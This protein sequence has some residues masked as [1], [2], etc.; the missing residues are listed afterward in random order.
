MRAALDHYGVPYTYFADQKLRDGNLRAKYDV[1]IYPARRR[2]FAVASDRHSQGRPRSGSLQ[3]NRADAEPRRARSERRYSRR[4]GHRRPGRARQVRGGRRHADHRRLHCGV[5]RRLRPGERRHRRASRAAVRARLDPARPILRIARA[6][7]PTATTERSARFISTRTRCSMRRPRRRLRRI[8]RWWPRRRIPAPMRWRRTSRPTPCRSI[9]RPTI[10]PPTSRS[11][12]P[13][14]RA[15]RCRGS[16][17]AAARCRRCVHDA[18]SARGD[19]VPAKSER[20]AAVR[21][22]RR[23]PGALRSRRWRSMCARQ[24]PHRDV[25]AAAVL[26]LADQ[27]TYFLGFNAILNWNHLDAGKGAEASSDRSRPSARR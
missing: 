14:K 2:N 13:P 15:R 3:E 26:A 18:A 9:F 27:G 7:S 25:R 6:P 5:H 12:E 1:I 10:N 22:A 17:A 24:R 23:R 21:N 8:W 20:H 11:A 16:D 19:A 4:H